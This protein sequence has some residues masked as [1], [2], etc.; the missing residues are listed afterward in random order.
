MVAGHSGDLPIVLLRI[1]DIENVDIVRELLQAHEYWRMKQLAV[2]LAILNDRQSSYIQELQ[3]AIET[4]SRA[5]QSSALPGTEHRPGRVFLLRSDLIAAEAKSLLSSIARVVLVAQRGT[6][7]EQLER[8]LEPAEPS[9]ATPRSVSD[10]LTAPGRA[11][12]PDLEF[13]NGL[14]GFARNGG[15]YVTVLG[16]GQ[17]TPAPWINVI[18]NPAFGFQAGTEGAGYTWSVN[19]RENQITP[20]SNDWAFAFA[21]AKRSTMRKARIALARRLAIIMDAMLRDGTRFVAA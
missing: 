5:N 14:G 10:R 2:D 9:K 3:I 1:A 21:I 12:A 13:F 15:E 6:L 8:V 4:L 7:F 19:S 17:S 18:A 11:G 16:P 20:W